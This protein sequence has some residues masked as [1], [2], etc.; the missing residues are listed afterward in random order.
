MG[1][2]IC[3]FGG[4]SVGSVEAFHHAAAI[5]K[6]QTNHWEQVVVVVSAMAGVTNALLSAVDAAANG[7]ETFYLGIIDEIQQRHF[8]TLQALLPESTAQQGLRLEIDQIIQSLRTFCHS[9]HVLGEVTPR[10]S[11]LISSLGERLCARIFSLLL[12]DLEVRSCAVDATDL[13]VTDD[14]FMSAVPLMDLCCNKIDQNLT[15]ILEKGLTPVVTG[16]LGATDSGIITTLGR[17]G[18][19]YTAAILA[20][21]LET[22]EVWI[23]TDVDG[24]MTADP[25]IVPH[26]RVLPQLSYLEICELA[27]F[28]A[29]V[30]HPKTIRPIIDLSL[31][32]RVKNTFN[33]LN[34]GTLICKESPVRPGKLTAITAINDISLVNV[35][36]LG[37]MG[38]PGIAARTFKA[39]AQEGASVL[40]ISQSSSEQSICFAIPSNRAF[41][42]VQSIKNEMSLELYRRDI[43][44]VD[45]IDDLVILTVIG[46]RLRERPGL[47]ALIFSALGKSNINVI[48]IAQGSSELSLSLVVATRDAY[49]AVRAIHSKVIDNNMEEHTI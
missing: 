27:Y 35:V 7:E 9:V 47:S 39:V 41:N 23:F 48:A 34:P 4:T 24:V 10:G 17:G 2:L 30:L 45:L 19:D 1:L 26:A 5:V 22:S 31:P 32:L 20:A 8:A 16:F 12:E 36:G 21:C 43:D 38:V 11:D 46:T 14:H 33:P 28:G 3:K 40:M 42:V 6:E 37:M 15:P 44:R 13:I 18:S 49:L 25:R 29:K